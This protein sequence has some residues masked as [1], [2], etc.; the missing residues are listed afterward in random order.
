MKKQILI[1]L[2]AMGILAPAVSFGQG[3][4]PMKKEAAK[5]EGK[6]D[7]KQAKGKKG[8]KEIY[9]TGISIS[10]WQGLI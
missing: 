6:M 3:G 9:L 2:L 7:K 10:C 4:A 5:K 8:N 1:A